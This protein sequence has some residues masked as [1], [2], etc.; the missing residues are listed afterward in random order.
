MIN[1]KEKAIDLLDGN[2]GVH[3]KCF[4]NRNAKLRL[5]R[6]RNSTSSKGDLN[7]F[8]GGRTK[9]EKER[10]KDLIKWIP[11]DQIEVEK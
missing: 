7:C 2:G 6:V 3:L 1:R 9:F 10:T 8:G 5:K 4:E 11:V